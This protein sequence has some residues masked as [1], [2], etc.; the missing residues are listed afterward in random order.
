MNSKSTDNLREQIAKHLKSEANADYLDRWEWL[1]LLS[2]DPLPITGT[3]TTVL[4][5]LAQRME[6]KMVYAPGERDMIALVHHFEAEFPG[7]K[8][9]KIVSSLVDY[10]IPNGD[11]SMARTVSLPAAVGVHMILSGQ[12]TQP[13]V[14]VPVIPELYNP[15]LDELATLNIRCKEKTQQV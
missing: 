6:K 11:S 9:E 3:E 15:V 1:G 12:F 10:G 7:G 14:H 2:N 13:G 5:E 4:D 8:K